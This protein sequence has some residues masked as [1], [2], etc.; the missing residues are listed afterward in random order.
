[1]QEKFSWSG[2][3]AAGVGAAAGY[4][5]GK[6]SFGQSLGGS[7]T[8]G[9]NLAQSGAS[10]IANAATRS[11]I[12]GTSFGDN[13][14]AAIPDV[15]GQAVGNA[16]GGAVLGAVSRATAKPSNQG[17]FNQSVNQ[18]EFNLPST[19]ASGSSRG[20]FIPNGVEFYENEVVVKGIRTFD[21]DAYVDGVLAYNSFRYDLR[22]QGRTR[23]SSADS[24]RRGVSGVNGLSG[25]INAGV[26]YVN[27][28]NKAPNSGWDANVDIVD[29]YN[30]EPYSLIENQVYKHFENKTFSGLSVESS[31]RGQGRLIQA[32]TF[33]PANEE[34]FLGGS[35]VT[36]S[37]VSNFGSASAFFD[38][39]MGKGIAKNAAE[40]TL[41]YAVING[42]IKTLRNKGALGLLSSAIENKKV[43][44]ATLF[45]VTQAGRA[46]SGVFNL[47]AGRNH[48]LTLPNEGAY[49]IRVDPLQLQTT[50]LFDVEISNYR[51]YS[52]T[53]GEI[54]SNR[55]STV[56][57]PE[58]PIGVIYE[59]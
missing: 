52:F 59:P 37:N 56:Y 33:V 31:K 39:T 58:R 57:R 51:P 25:T 9:G 23:V 35:T 43:A 50:T 54:V 40:F 15:I 36:F 4:Q 29:F 48:Q 30:G 2:V 32:S 22:S 19:S 44:E 28:L 1:M 16:L 11:A 13:I 20:Y 34:A 18:G 14:R 3:A 21:R 46:R 42:G 45:E 24:Y 49:I 17:E 47:Y 38:P 5:F 7:R 26:D 53:G 27:G 10:A 12:E 6:S 41:Q 55:T 8:F